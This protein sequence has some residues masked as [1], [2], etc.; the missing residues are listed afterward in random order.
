MM[1]TYKPVFYLLAIVL[2]FGSCREEDER[3][4]EQIERDKIIEIENTLRTH[5]WGFNDLKVSVKYETRATPLLANVADENGMVQPGVYDSYDIFGNG[6]RQLYYTYQFTRDKIN[7]D[8][9]E[10]GNYHRFGGYFVLNSSEIRVNPD[11][12]NALR[13]QYNYNPENALFTM[14]SE[15][16]RNQAFIDFVNSTIYHSILSGRPGEIADAVVDKILNS[17]EIANVIEQLLYDLIHGK[18][19]EITQSPEEAAGVLARAIV[20]KL[21][22]IDWELLLYDKILELLQKLQVD[23]PEE[24]AAELAQ[25]MADKIQSS[26]SQ[27][28]IY[29]LLLP[30]LEEI[31]NETLPVIANKIANAVYGLIVDKLNYDT[32]YQKLYPLWEQFTLA[33]SSTIIETSDTLASVV[34]NHFF[35]VDTLTESLIPF[36]TKVDETIRLGELAQE[37]IDSVLIPKVNEINERFPGLELSPDWETVKQYLTG[38]LTA[39][40]AALGSSTVE[41]LSA[42]LANAVNT[43][44]K[45]TLQKGFETAIFRLQKI[46]P[47]IASSTITAWIINLVEM[48]EQ[49]VVDFIEEKLNRIFDRFD[50][51]AIAADISEIIY[52]KIVDV[53]NEENLYQLILPI[54]ESLNEVDMERVARLLSK[55]LIESGIIQ[56]NISE[57]QVIAKLTEILSD[58]IGN[59]NP[60]ET[61]EKLVEL[62]LNSNI[63]N[64]I[65]GKILS[66]FL[67]L[68]IYQLLLSIGRNINAIDL[69]EV[70]IKIK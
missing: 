7:V 37:I 35:N 32:I 43:V 41:E 56:D 69:I 33:D 70:S 9:N 21:K 6:K 2:F 61:T 39:I 13:F 14:Q 20:E 62:I 57:E 24:T 63:V 52:N 11:S 8:T 29:D 59:I 30:I 54:L 47:D 40:K 58:L 68:K 45:S 17:E 10:S 25:R 53:F 31:E 1:F 16:A 67:E 60:D 4:P 15:Y 65:D 5:N 27:S 46:P 49:P 55:W 44:M 66:K 48:A 3:T 26:I 19:D 22:E 51:E 12:T 28:D 42:T 36:I 50:A 38:V 34:A 64:N 18:I 23:N